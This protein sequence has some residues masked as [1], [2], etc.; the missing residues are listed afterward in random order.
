MRKCLFFIGCLLFF[1]VPL[2]ILEKPVEA[3]TGPK[4]AVIVEIIGLEDKAYAVT[5]LGKEPT[6]PYGDGDYSYL[7]PH[8]IM[9]Y[10]DED[11][12]KF[13][14]D[15]WECN[16]NETVTWGYY[17]PNP[18]KVFIILDDGSTFITQELETYAFRSYY[19]MDV[20]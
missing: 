6:P 3:D 14:G 18:F 17:P 10:R 7:D 12:Y 5:F 13:V 1:S 8:P 16:G 4:P 19:Q 15:Y 9:N 11:G 2:F 20:S